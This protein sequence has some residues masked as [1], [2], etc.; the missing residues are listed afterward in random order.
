[1]DGKGR[2]FTAQECRQEL[3]RNKKTSRLYAP[4]NRPPK[5]LQKCLWKAG[6]SLRSWVYRM[7]RLYRGGMRK[8][9]MRF[10]KQD[11]TLQG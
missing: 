1:M 5:G 6:S 4:L 3:E 10:A 11:R 9:R 2:G 7:I 8:L